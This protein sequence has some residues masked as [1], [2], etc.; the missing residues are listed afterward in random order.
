MQLSIQKIFFSLN[1]LF[2]LLLLGILVLANQLL[3]ISDYSNRL[4]TLKDQH[5]LI[6]KIIKTDFHDFE[7]ATI[8]LNGELAE[9]ALN[10]KNSNNSVWLESFFG[11]QNRQA[12]LHKR[13]ITSSKDFQ[14][15]AHNWAENSTPSKKMYNEMINT[16]PRYFIAIDAMM[17]FEIQRINDSIQLTKQIAIFLLLLSII[18]F[19]IHRWRLKQVYQDI[20]HACSVD[21]DGKKP[22]ILTSEIDFLLKRLSR[23]IPVTSSNTTLINPNSGILNEKGMV[24]TYAAK[25]NNQSSSSL[26]LVLFAI[27]QQRTLAD[28]LSKEELGTMYKKLT[29]IL[30][31]YEQPLDIIAH[32]ENNT[33]AFLMARSSK[34]TALN[35]AEQIIASVEE[36][37][38]L[39]LHDPIKLTLSGGLMLKIPSQTIEESLLSAEKILQKAKDAGGNRIAQLR[40]GTDKYR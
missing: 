5:I 39:T 18:T 2:F 31:M 32:L 13:L 15:A 25:R 40:E 23:K 20:E 8:N 34:D 22:K 3:I 14:E 36:S 33:F 38:F 24:N 17:D 11:D 37:S 12:I 16:L 35:E 7:L 4:A 27:D 1:A 28:T 6:D 29:E 26:Y 19:L 30:S 9:L 21:N 10:T